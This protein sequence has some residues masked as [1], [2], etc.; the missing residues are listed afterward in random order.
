[1]RTI[2]SPTTKSLSTNQ[3]LTPIWMVTTKIMRTR[4]NLKVN[5]RQPQPYNHEQL[6]RPNR[7]GNEDVLQKTRRMTRHQL[8]PLPVSRKAATLMTL[9][10]PMT[11]PAQVPPPAQC[12]HCVDNG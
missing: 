2:L 8:L 1:M 11:T 5:Q 12:V 4:K 10:P 7:N 3:S 9:M 6:H